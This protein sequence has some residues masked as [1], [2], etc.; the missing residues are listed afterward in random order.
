[1]KVNPAIFVGG[2]AGIAAGLRVEIHAGQWNE[3]GD[4]TPIE[5]AAG[6]LHELG[7]LYSALSPLG[8]GGSPI[9]YDGFPWQSSISDEN[10]SLILDKCFGIRQ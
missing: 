2:A 4:I 9:R 5:Q 6:L 10:Q 1:M 7:H 3:V 8:S